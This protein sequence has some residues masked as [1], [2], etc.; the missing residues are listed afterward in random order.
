MRR[1]QLLDS[2]VGKLDV[3]KVVLGK[4]SYDEVIDFLIQFYKD[5]Q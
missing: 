2:T 1:V 4:N 5:N 3:L